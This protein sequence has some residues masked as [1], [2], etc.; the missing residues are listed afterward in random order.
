MKN[1]ILIIFLSVLA[2]SCEQEKELNFVGDLT[3]NSVLSFKTQVQKC[4]NYDLMRSNIKEELL[5]HKLFTKKE[6]GLPVG[7]CEMAV[8][9]IMPIL[10]TVDYPEYECEIL[11]KDI[12]GDL[13]KKEICDRFGI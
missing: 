8:N 4:K 10:P 9:V 1:L 6:K 13:I 7:I 2:L 3:L 12:A 5:K 11:M